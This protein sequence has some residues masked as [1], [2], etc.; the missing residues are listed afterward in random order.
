M[1]TDF[2]DKPPLSAAFADTTPGEGASDAQATAAAASIGG[3]WWD[4]DG[5]PVKAE[6][7]WF[8]EPLDKEKRGR[9]LTAKAH[10]S[11]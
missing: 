10:H 5:E 11:G 4:S 7:D 2:I 1:V 3:W 8:M 9:F 6:C